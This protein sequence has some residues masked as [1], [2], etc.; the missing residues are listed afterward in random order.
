[1]ANGAA[2][3]R[4][5]EPGPGANRCVLQHGFGPPSL[6]PI[7]EHMPAWSRGGDIPS[8]LP[9]RARTPAAVSATPPPNTRTRRRGRPAALAPKLSHSPWQG[10]TAHDSPREAPL[11]CCPSARCRRAKQ[12]IAALD[13]L[14]CLRT[15]RSLAELEAVARASPLARALAAVPPPFDPADLNER[16]ERLA[17]LAEIRR[18]HEAEM[19]AAW[20]SGALDRLYGPWRRGG[21]LLQ[22]PPRLYAEA[23]RRPRR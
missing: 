20:K 1:M 9:S 10:L 8:A 12:C 7:L 16:M 2:H 11:P 4:R 3:A 13:N 21:V 19:Q 6:P 15:H 18:A 22:P 14:Y 5:Q 23:A 17:E